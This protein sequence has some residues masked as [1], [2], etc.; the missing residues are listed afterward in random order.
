MVKIRCKNFRGIELSKE[1]KSSMAATKPGRKKAS[2]SH[3]DLKQSMATGH[4][5]LPIL[6]RL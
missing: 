6:N 3:Y 4:Y 2:V 1:A 5:I